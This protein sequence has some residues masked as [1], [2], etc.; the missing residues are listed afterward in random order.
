MTADLTHT[1][2]EIGYYDLNF[3]FSL[4][5][6]TN[7]GEQWDWWFSS[8]QYFEFDSTGSQDVSISY[9]LRELNWVVEYI[10]QEVGDEISSLTFPIKHKLMDGM[11]SV[12]SFYYQNPK[13]C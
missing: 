7:E 13:N 12:N 1:V 10:E 2:N 11:K 4:L 5:I 8:Y 3:E 9:P 6:D